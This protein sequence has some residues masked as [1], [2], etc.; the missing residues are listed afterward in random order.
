MKEIITKSPQETIKLGERIGQQLR[1][2]EVISLVGNLGTG[3]THIIKGIAGGVSEC[4]EAVEGFVNSP[5]FVLVN[6]YLDGRLEIYHIDAYRLSSATEFELL[7]FDDLCH[8]NSVVL[9]E[10]ADKVSKSLQG[11]DMTELELEHV[12]GSERL[13]RFKKMP[14]YIHL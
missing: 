4:S 12:S 5:T 7:G 1:G 10:W 6:E 13:V 14:A 9:I 2:G 11:I 3:K 8:D